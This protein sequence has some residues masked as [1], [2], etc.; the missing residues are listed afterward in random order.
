VD[1][2]EELSL[3]GLK[4]L[5]PKQVIFEIERISASKK[6]LRFREEAKLALKLLNKSKFKKPD[7]K[8]KNTDKGIIAYSK[9]H[10][11]ITATLDRELKQ[12]VKGQ[13]MV[14]RGKKKLE[15]V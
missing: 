12:K 9:K 4:I 8:N 5:I 3:Q 14:I 11:I 15:I 1:F 7:L 10:D 13:R 2:I 6:K